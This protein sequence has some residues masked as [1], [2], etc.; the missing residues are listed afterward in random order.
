VA[1]PVAEGGT[2]P[3]ITLNLVAQTVGMVK[4][5]ATFGLSY[6]TVADYQQ[7]LGYCQGEVT[8]QITH[9]LENA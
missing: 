5:A 7:I 9:D 6:E 1:A 2:K 4:L 3:D 8:R